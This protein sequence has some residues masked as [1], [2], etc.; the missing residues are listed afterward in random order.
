MTAKSF[1]A[2]P[3][4]ARHDSK[5]FFAFRYCF[6]IESCDKEDS[7]VNNLSDFTPG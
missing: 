2:P 1:F 3:G 7:K 6:K 4:L 5:E